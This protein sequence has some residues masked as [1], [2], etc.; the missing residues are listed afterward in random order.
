MWGDEEQL[1]KR[2]SFVKKKYWSK[3]KPN[4]TCTVIGEP[5]SRGVYPAY[6]MDTDHFEDPFVGAVSL[7]E[8]S[9]VEVVPAPLSVPDLGYLVM[10]GDD[11]D[12]PSFSYHTN[13]PDA[14]VEVSK[15]TNAFGYAP[16]VLQR[17]ACIPA[18]K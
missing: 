14:A 17:F 13:E 9:D 6:I 7:A 12:A 18:K 16:V 5:D 3:F 4:V 11:P 1:G 15:R 10:Y 2:R 8:W